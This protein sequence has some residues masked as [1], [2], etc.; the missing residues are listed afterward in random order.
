MR[1]REGVPCQTCLSTHPVATPQRRRD[2]PRCDAD[3]HHWHQ[4]CLVPGFPILALGPAKSPLRSG[5]GPDMP[6][7]SP[8]TFHESE[9]LQSLGSNVPAAG[10]RGTCWVS[11]RRGSFRGNVEPPKDAVHC[12]YQRCKWWR[13]RR[14]D[15]WGNGCPQ[16]GLT[17]PSPP[18]CCSGPGSQRPSRECSPEEISVPS[19]G[20]APAACARRAVRQQG[21]AHQCA[22]ARY[23]Q[24]AVSAEWRP[25]FACVRQKATESGTTGG[26][27]GL[28]PRL[29]SAVVFGLHGLILGTT[30]QPQP[31]N[32]R[33]RHHQRWA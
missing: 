27:C 17:H 18:R 31:R 24:G 1:R 21:V 2:I 28:I 26:F 30:G 13:W 12:L 29:S 14:E 6:C 16:L 23:W 10:S 19:L 3:L 8:S 4:A 7:A 11:R 22:L 5:L 15:P 20:R 9:A 32:V 25:L 33:G